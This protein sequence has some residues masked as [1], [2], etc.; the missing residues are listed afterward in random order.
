LAL[1]VMNLSKSKNHQSVVDSREFLG[2]SHQPKRHKVLIHDTHQE[3]R[4]K[5]PSKLWQENYNK[6]LQKSPKR[7]TGEATQGLEEPR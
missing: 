1:Q 2:K 6:E 7:K 4:K 5:S 3:S